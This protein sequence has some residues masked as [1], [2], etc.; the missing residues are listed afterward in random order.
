ME[1]TSIQPESIKET[2]PRPRWNV[3]GLLVD[4]LTLPQA[5]ERIVEWVEA[6]RSNAQAPLRLIVTANPEY[7]MAARRDPTF[8]ALVNSADVLTPDGAGLMLAGKLLGQPFKE[9]VTGVALC[10]ALFAVAAAHHLRLFL[11]GAGPGVAEQAATVLR[12]QYPGINIAGCWAG[13]SGPEGD[14]ESLCRITEARAEIVLVAYG[15]LRQDW[16]AARNL[17]KSGATVAIGIGGVLD[18]KS[19]RVSLA[20]RR[21]RQLGLEWLYRLYK[22]PWRW[23]RQLALVGF[24]VAVYRQAL[25]QIG[26]KI[27]FPFRSTGHL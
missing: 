1:K 25:R 18:Y 13:Q 8:L 11:L 12:E 21:V 27:R 10:E 9:R 22:E 23:R 15:M 6:R 17:Q 2:A 5:V 14:E 7:V 26:Q 3:L 20:P 24:A 16:W 19:G 4:D